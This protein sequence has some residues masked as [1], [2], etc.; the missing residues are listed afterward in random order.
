MDAYGF[1]KST[2]SRLRN[3]D[4]NRNVG[5]GSDI[6]V[7]KKLYFTVVR[8][9][10]DVSQAAD[11][12]KARDAV[13]RNDIRFVIAT[14]FKTLVAY[15]LKADERL[16]VTLDELAKEYGFFL[17]LA[18]YEKA[19]MYS[20]HP[21]DLKASEKMGQL[22]D[23]IRERNDL[24]KPEDIHALNVFLTPIS[25]PSPTLRSSSLLRSRVTVLLGKP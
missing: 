7:K 18:G 12:L 8:S 19:I 11:A 4:D 20:E 2:V 6:G 17:P 3:S 13:T 9:G 10:A 23:L 14:D 25:E 5:E 15:D 22:F 1:P 21:A 16:E 24:S